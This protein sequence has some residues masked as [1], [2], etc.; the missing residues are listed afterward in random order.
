M[1]YIMRKY[2]LIGGIAIAAMALAQGR[3]ELEARLSGQ[4]KGKVTWKTRGAQQAELEGEG[5]M[6]GLRNTSLLVAIG[7]NAPIK[8]NTNS[9]GRW[10][11]ETRFG[12]TGRPTIAIGDPVTVSTGDGVIVLTGLFQNR[13]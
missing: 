5:E 3:I 7:S 2:L 1:E 12:S 10:E 6:R 8:V 11:F 9:F 4:G 13:R